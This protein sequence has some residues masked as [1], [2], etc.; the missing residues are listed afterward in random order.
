[1][2][3]RGRGSVKWVVAAEM[4]ALLAFC[5]VV[6]GDPPPGVNE[7]HYLVKAKNFW[8]PQWCQNDLFAASGKAHLTFYL[9][10]GWP[11]RWFSLAT[12]A[13]IGR[14]VGWTILSAGL[15]SLTRSLRLP[16][17]TAWVVAVVWTAGVQWGN[18]A[19]EWV[20]GGIEAKVPA[21]GLVLFGLA[22]IVRG[23]W[24]TVWLWLGGAA[25]WH[26]LT[27]GWA[28]V[29]A[30]FAFAVTHRRH[31][32][33][34]GDP[35]RVLGDDAD[36]SRAESPSWI[37]AWLRPS[38]FVG[39]LISLAGLLPAL[40]MTAGATPQESVSAA[41]TYS[42]F[43]IAH[44]LLPSAFAGW[45]YL[46]H[47]LLILLTVAAMIGWRQ[48]R[49]ER[50]R[51]VRPSDAGELPGATGTPGW[52]RLAAFGL[53]AVAVSVTGLLVG[54]LPAVAPDLAAKLL[55]FYWFRLGDAV[56]PLLLG[57]AVAGLLTQAAGTVAARWSRRRIVGAA[58]LVTATGCCAWSTW[59]QTRDGVPVSVSNQLLGLD[60]DADFATQRQTMRDWLDVCRFVRA[61]TPADAVFLTPRHQQTFK[62]YAHRA[63][64]VNWKDVPQDVPSLREWSGRFVEVFPWHLSTMRVTI[65]YPELRRLR[66]RYGVT[67]LIVDRR[68]VGPQLP[69]VQV[70]P[71]T[72]NQNATYAVYQLP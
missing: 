49:T 30:T 2:K 68:V 38:L 22:D 21:Y 56:V 67:W 41:R 24:N 31:Q 25:A 37:L 34:Q 29:A 60:A 71:V 26:V 59:T 17:G 5:F 57:C 32:R 11:T 33:Y 35:E 62:W 70:Y 16:A 45:W 52:D 42:Y 23:R 64:V 27:G 69:L 63:E 13:W 65:R 44:H 3:P 47:A 18:L 7:A 61:S 36:R 66:R 72:P 55:R 9:L 58:M 1:M 54:T 50:G 39:G 51:A 40:A 43:R 8:D 4:A 10:L 46:R 28:V 6:G 53:G 14:F 12:T 15:I 20:I 19:G 48:T